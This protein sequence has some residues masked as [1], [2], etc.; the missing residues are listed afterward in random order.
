MSTWEAIAEAIRMG[1]TD[2]HIEPF[3]EALRLRYRIDGVL[4]RQPT[5]PQINRFQAAIISRLK[6]MAGADMAERRRHQDGRRDSRQRSHRVSS[7]TRPGMSRN[8]TMGDQPIARLSEAVWV[9]T[10]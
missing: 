6:I 3:E 2:I 1:A 10:S 9:R 4:Q 5:P 8:G 7:A